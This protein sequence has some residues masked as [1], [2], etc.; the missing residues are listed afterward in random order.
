MEGS[1]GQDCSMSCGNCVSGEACNPIDGMCPSGCEPGWVVGLC[2]EGKSG[3]PSIMLSFVFKN[4]KVNL[5]KV[6]PNISVFAM[7]MYNGS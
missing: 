7:P 4:K 6:V 1:Y 2:S 5:L 3:G